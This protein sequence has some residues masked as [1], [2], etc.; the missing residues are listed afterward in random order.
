M[1]RRNFLQLAALALAGQAAERVWPFR[2]YSIPKEIVIAKSEYLTSE[3]S[4]KFTDAF[5]VLPVV[6]AIYRPDGSPVG[7]V[8]ITSVNGKVLTCSSG[9]VRCKPG[10]LLFLEKEMYP[11]TL[12]KADPRT[13]TFLNLARS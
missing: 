11:A 10:D 3:T 6:G 13:G 4:E 1:D 9:V 2:V 12:H 7:H 8:K 5:R